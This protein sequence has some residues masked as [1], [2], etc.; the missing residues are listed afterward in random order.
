MKSLSD[1]AGWSKALRGL[2][3]SNPTIQQDTKI[4]RGATH[5]SVEGPGLQMLNGYGS[6]THRSA[7]CPD[8]ASVQCFALLARS[9]HRKLCF[10]VDGKKR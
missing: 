7:V 1:P 9:P 3:S 10:A 6:A 4:I 8:L 5:P 2:V